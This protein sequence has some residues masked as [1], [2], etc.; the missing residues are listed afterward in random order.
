MKGRSKPISAAKPELSSGLLSY[1]S[2]EAQSNMR[3][4]N[5]PIK[6]ATIVLQ[7]NDK[8]VPVNDT[9]N[10]IQEETESPSKWL[11][12]KSR[13]NQSHFQ[14]SQSTGTKHFKLFGTG[15]KISESTQ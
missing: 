3:T 5:S 2:S 7:E 1:S 11:A 12:T 10:E 15:S 9:Y 13:D 4:I 8:L 14:P 6:V